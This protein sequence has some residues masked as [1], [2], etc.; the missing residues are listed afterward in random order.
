MIEKMNPNLTSKSGA[1]ASNV[2]YLYGFKLNA[3]RLLEKF[4]PNDVRM[5]KE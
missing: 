5:T 4:R 2:R 3:I 1:V